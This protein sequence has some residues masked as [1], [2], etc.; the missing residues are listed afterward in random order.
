MRKVANSNELNTCF[1]ELGF[2]N[3]ITEKL[4]LLKIPPCLLRCLSSKD[5][6]N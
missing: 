1:F 3:Y 5:I 4:L 6:L 2:L